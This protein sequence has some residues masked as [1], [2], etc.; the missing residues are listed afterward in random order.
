MRP[1]VGSAE[2]DQARCWHVP[3]SAVACR[4]SLIL[5]RFACDGKV[6][7]VNEPAGKRGAQPADG[8]A[9]TKKGPAIQGRGLLVSDHSSHDQTVAIK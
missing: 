5:S 9:R 1:G 7:G 2:R 4:T 8:V 3:A 6:R